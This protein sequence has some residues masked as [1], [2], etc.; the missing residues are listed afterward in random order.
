MLLSEGTLFDP[1]FYAMSNPEVVATYGSSTEALVW[2]YLHRGKAEGRPPMA[3]VV[4]AK[5]PEIPH[6]DPNANQTSSSSDDDDDDDD[7]DDHKDETPAPVVNTGTVVDGVVQVNGETIGQLNDDNMLIVDGGKSVNVPLS[8]GDA[9][10]VSSLKDIDWD[11]TGAGASVTD[12]TNGITVTRSADVGDARFTVTG[13][14]E[15]TRDELGN[16]LDELYP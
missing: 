2:H 3:P 4:T 16:Y 9:G 8:L 10:N 14:G 7:D 15:L 1:A 13:Q 12:T 6:F 5:E 11:S